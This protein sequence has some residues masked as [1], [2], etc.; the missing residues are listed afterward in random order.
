MY[1]WILDVP[2]NGNKETINVNFALHNLYKN[3]K[4]EKLLLTE[5]AGLLILKSQKKIL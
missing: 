3:E 1:E 2:L 5:T 4:D